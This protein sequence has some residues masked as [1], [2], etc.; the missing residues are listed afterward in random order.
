MI[1][2]ESYLLRSWDNAHSIYGVSAQ[3]H[4]HPNLML[5]LNYGFHVNKTAEDE[6]YHALD[7]Q[8]YWRF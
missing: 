6:R 7:L 3:Y 2:H 1:I 4:F 8:C 5:Q